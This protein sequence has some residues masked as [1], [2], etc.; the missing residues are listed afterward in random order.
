MDNYLV[1]LSRLYGQ[2][3][4]YRIR[5]LVTQV[6]AFANQRYVRQNQNYL[7]DLANYSP[8]EMRLNTEVMRK[9]ED[10]PDK[11]IESMVWFLPPFTSITAGAENI[12]K[13]IAFFHNKGIKITIALIALRGDFERSKQAIIG[14]LG[15][16]KGEI[17]I[18]VN[19]APRDL[20]FSDAGVATYWYTAY[21]LL[22]YSNTKSKFYFIQDD[23]RLL[24]PA[25][26]EYSLAEATYG[27]DFIG[28]TN[29]E[30]LKDM[31]INE[32]GGKA[33]S[34]FPFPAQFPRLTGLTVKKGI[35]RIFF[36]SRPDVERNGLNL[37]LAGL[38]EIK[39]R[40]P[41]VEIVFAGSP[42][43]FNDLGLK[44]VQAG[45]ISV[46]KLQSFYASFD[47]GIYI[48]LSRHT[49]VIP[50]ELMASG[51]AVMTNRHDF[52]Q[53]YLK[54]DDNCVIFDLAPNSMADAYDKLYSNVDL[55]NT[56][57][58]NG[59]SFISGMPSLEDEME[60]IRRFMTN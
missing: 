29:A 17:E 26:L 12:L 4:D 43:K 51:C 59:L 28:I 53:S 23:E 6:W 44:A 31:Y 21:S 45:S 32:F 50:F 57:V 15:I 35:R 36:Y 9:W 30:C 8:D 46:A 14:K 10:T 7:I 20:P 5:S 48:I 11:K 52:R 37:G 25:S 24:Y 27:F 58:A 39:K 1:L 33:E 56:I 47:V 34:Y 18:L 49:G 16:N 42:Y 13:F 2:I 60:R 19:P 22:K 41:D 40:H 55:Y 54:P 38:I 3:K